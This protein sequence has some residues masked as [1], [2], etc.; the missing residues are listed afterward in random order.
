[1][2]AQ[3]VHVLLLRERWCPV[4]LPAHCPGSPKIYLV[5]L[6]KSVL[7][8]MASGDAKDSMP[9]E[10]NVVISNKTTYVFIFWYNDP[11]FGNW[12]WRYIT[13]TMQKIYLHTYIGP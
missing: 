10:G 5:A 3:S 2:R 7:F 6:R 11:A 4:S 9:I 13:P 12:S 8:Y 1:M